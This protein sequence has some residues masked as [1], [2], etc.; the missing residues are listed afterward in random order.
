MHINTYLNFPGNTAEAIEFYKEVL[1]A[2]TLMISRM[3]DAP[4]DVPP[5]LKDKIMHAR[6]KIGD[7]IIFVSDTFDPSKLVAGNNASLALDAGTP[8]RVD[9]LFAKL[10]AGG[11]VTLP[12]NDAFW[13]ARFGMLIDKF[14]VHW[15]LTAELKK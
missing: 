11:T 15:M 4:M 5:E 8:A 7:T 2:E 3:G 12:P 1:G 13:G 9:E 6:L 14:G 10:S